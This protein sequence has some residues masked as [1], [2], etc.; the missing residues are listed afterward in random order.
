MWKIISL[1]TL[2]FKQFLPAVI[3][4]AFT[5]YLFTI[6]GQKLPNLPWAEKISL[7][8]I[9]HLGLFMVLICLF[10][11]P[12]NKSIITYKKR[13]NWFL[14]FSLVGVIYGISIEFIQ[15]YYIPN[16]SFDLFDILADTIGCLVGYYLAKRVFKY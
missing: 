3:Y 6:P 9:V 8:K 14:F 1:K 13:L 7:D 11:Y 15:K 2:R 5:F 16:R 12:F 10:A 4:L